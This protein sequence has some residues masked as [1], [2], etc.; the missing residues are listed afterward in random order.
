M[1]YFFQNPVTGEI[2]IGFSTDPERRLADLNNATN[3]RSRGAK[4]R[5]LGEIDGGR[6]EERKLHKR[7]AEHR[8]EYALLFSSGGSE[9]F[10]C[11]I[12]DDVMDLLGTQEGAD[13]GGMAVLRE[14]LRVVPPVK[15]PKPPIQ[16]SLF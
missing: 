15:A 7:F 16:T 1:I 9:W 13:E 14:S 8:R 2:K 12:Y 6:R 5:S 10:S 4:L 11:D 3:D